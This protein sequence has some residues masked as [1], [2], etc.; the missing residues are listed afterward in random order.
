VLDM[1]A[2]PIAVLLVSCLC[3]TSSLAA[4]YTEPRQ[5]PRHTYDY[6][7]VGGE[8]SQWLFEETYLIQPVFKL[9]M[10]EM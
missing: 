4:L 10:P 2:P 8:F 7:I 1:V 6:V 5:L 3:F 9:E